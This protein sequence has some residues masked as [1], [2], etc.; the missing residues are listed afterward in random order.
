VNSATTAANRTKR[1]TAG[2]SPAGSSPCC[3][4]GASDAARR[5]GVRA[6]ERAPGE[7]AHRPRV[8]ERIGDPVM[9]SPDLA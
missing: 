7:Q 2:S 9:I 8:G 5:G 1:N 6:G 3:W 4:H